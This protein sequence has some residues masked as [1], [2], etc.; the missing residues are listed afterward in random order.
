M[1]NANSS[2]SKNKAFSP[3]FLI[4]FGLRPDQTIMEEANALQT[5]AVEGS[6]TTLDEAAMP[7]PSSQRGLKRKSQD[8]DPSLPVRSLWFLLVATVLPP[9]ILLNP[10]RKP[11][12]A[13][14]A[15]HAAAGTRRRC[16]SATGSRRV[17][18]TP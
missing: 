12:R 18:F 4:K 13:A 14:A 7:P 2:Q 8:S 6:R 3:L 15:A 16:L 10:D 5:S 17:E 9:L 1:D 11:G